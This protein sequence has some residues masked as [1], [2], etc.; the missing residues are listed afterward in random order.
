MLVITKKS[1]NINI[2]PNASFEIDL[3]NIEWY[4]TNK[5]ILHKITNSGVPIA[6]RFLSENPDIKDGDI[7]WQEENKLIAVE[8]TPCDCIVIKARSIL[9][10]SA[11]CY[12]IGNRHLP[13][14]HED[15]ILLIPHEVP[16]YNLL[17]AAGYDLEI[18]KKK[19]AHP[20]KTTVLPHLRIGITD[21][22]AVTSLKMQRFEK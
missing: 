9:E 11:I 1:G 17:K 12:E 16:V 18:K 21:S 4:E 6:L 3:V 19:L 20:F 15:N 10:A 13:L 7:L 2:S 5:R 8:I 22:A 14:F